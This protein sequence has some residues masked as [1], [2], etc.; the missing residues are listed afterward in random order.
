MKCQCGCGQLAPLSRQS[1]TK[2]GHVKGQPLRYIAGH[3]QSSK[4]TKG[5]RKRG[6]GC[7]LLHRLRAET[8]L[9]KPLPK[10]AV[11]H[12]ADGSLRDDAPLVI[13]QDERYH[14]LLHRRMK[15]QKAGGNPNTDKV[16]SRCRCV[17]PRSAFPSSAA[18]P[19]GLCYYCRPCYVAWRAARQIE[20]QL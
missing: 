16:C 12:H 2:L 15:V 11:V 14:N 13:C 8:A 10:Y 7:K 3:Y 19:D 20:V 17:K 1:N 18:Q 6:P 4:P 5:Y 9:G